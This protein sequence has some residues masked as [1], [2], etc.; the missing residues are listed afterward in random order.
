MDPQICTQICRKGWSKEGHFNNK[1]LQRK[2]DFLLTYFFFG[3]S[4]FIAKMN[5]KHPCQFRKHLFEH[6]VDVVHKIC[7]EEGNKE[8]KIFIKKNSHVQ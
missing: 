5:I 7:F 3:N 4:V 8:F 1:L 2:R 6:V